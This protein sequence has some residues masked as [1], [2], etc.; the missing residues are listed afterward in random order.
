M[1]RAERPFPEQKVSHINVPEAGWVERTGYWSYWARV[2]GHG[3]QAMAM[4][5]I[6]L[7][8]IQAFCGSQAVLEYVQLASVTDMAVRVATHGSA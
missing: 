4:A 8:L 2:S 3:R 7:W 5:G 6:E 1:A